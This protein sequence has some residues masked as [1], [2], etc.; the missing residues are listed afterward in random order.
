[1]GRHG[2]LTM[3]RRVNRTQ[4]DPDDAAGHHRRNTGARDQDI[5]C[6]R[7]ARRRQSV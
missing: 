5:K 7:L 4:N 2:L 3:G 6:D 1:M